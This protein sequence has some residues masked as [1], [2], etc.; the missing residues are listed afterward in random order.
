MRGEDQQVIAG[1]IGISTNQL[2][3]ELTAGKTIAAIATEHKVTAATVVN[4]LVASENAEIDQRIASGQMT[5]A[6]GAQMK[7]MT[8]QRVTAEV[9]GT[10]PS[11]GF[12]GHDGGA[13]G[14]PAGSQ[15]AN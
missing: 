7:T 11:G 1:A 4:A 2:Q 12:G 15:P 9:N 3:T 13:P 10:E 8:V 5:A 14:A 6:Q